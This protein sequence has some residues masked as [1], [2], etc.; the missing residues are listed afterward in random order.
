MHPLCRTGSRQ[1]CRSENAVDLFLTLRLI[2]CPNVVGFHFCNAWAAVLGLLML[3]VYTRSI[4]SLSAVTLQAGKWQGWS[5]GSHCR[6]GSL[7]AWYACEM[8]FCTNNPDSSQALSNQAG[9]SVDA[10]FLITWHTTKLNQNF[11]REEENSFK[12]LCQSDPYLFVCPSLPL[13]QEKENW[14]TAF[15]LSENLEWIPQW[16]MDVEIFL[17]KETCPTSWII[18]SSNLVAVKLSFSHLLR[19]SCSLGAGLSPNAWWG[20]SVQRHKW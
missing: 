16:Y 8:F 6:K 19:I 3:N 17:F 20:K 15:S 4:I 18:C 14:D 5:P 13:S 7:V 10:T 9:N 1:S 11:M 2:S 12:L